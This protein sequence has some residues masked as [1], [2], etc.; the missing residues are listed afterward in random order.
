MNAISLFSGIGGIDLAAEWAGIDV[1]TFCERE[2]FCQKVLKKHW[3]KTPI[4]DDVCTLTK[5]RLDADGIDTKSIDFIFGG[6]PCQPFSSAGKQK[7]EDDDR[8]LWPEVYRIIKDIRPRWFLGENVI[9][10]VTLGLDRVLSDLESE[11][12]IAR[13]IVL[14]ACAVNAPFRRD[15]VFVMAF[16][17]GIGLEKLSK[18]YREI[19][20]LYDQTPDPFDPFGTVKRFYR[21][22]NLGYIRRGD[23]IPDRAHRIKAIG[24][25]VNPYQIYPILAAIKQIHDNLNRE[26][27]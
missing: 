14:P 10:H 12:Y 2:P 23:G 18:R 6:Y 5:E 21:S 25:T 3:P 17:A 4:Y 26:G 20:T 19:E 13:A 7:G 22:R 24:N 1:I 15:R 11:N 27:E 8:H 9:G 16:T